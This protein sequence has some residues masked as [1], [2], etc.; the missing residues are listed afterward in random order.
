MTDRNIPVQILNQSWRRIS[1]S[2][3]CD[4]HRAK[5]QDDIPQVQQLVRTK[6]TAEGPHQP[7]EHDA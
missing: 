6:V 5:G 7:P 3:P 2:S 4:L 1:E